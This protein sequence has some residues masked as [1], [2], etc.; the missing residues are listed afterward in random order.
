[1][2]NSYCRFCGAK[3]AEEDKFCRSCGAELNPAIDSEKT[4]TKKS[5]DYSA[6]IAIGAII[7]LVLTALIIVIRMVC[8]YSEPVSTPAPT[9]EVISPYF[10]ETSIQETIGSEDETKQN[11]ISPEEFAI[12]ND[13]DWPKSSP[14]DWSTSR[15]PY[16]D[17]IKVLSIAS[18]AA[19]SWDNILNYGD[20]DVYAYA[21]SYVEA[22]IDGK[23]DLE[24][25]AIGLEETGL[26]KKIFGKNEYSKYIYNS[27]LSAGVSEY[28]AESFMEHECYVWDA[29]WDIYKYARDTGKNHEKA[30]DSVNWGCFTSGNSIGFD[31]FYNRFF[32]YSNHV[33]DASE[34][35]KGE[36]E[37]LFRILREYYEG[38]AELI[39]AEKSG[40]ERYVRIIKSD[41]YTEQETPQSSCFS[42]VGYDSEKEELHV[43]FRTSGIEYIYYKFHEEDWN[44]FISAESLGTYFN[45]NI[46]GNFDYIKAG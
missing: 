41:R 22:R 20:D 23:C 17:R 35:V 37:E 2:N 12:E 6:F 43:V 45:N 46:K 29:A 8:N 40:G 4:V 10:P 1:M 3:I 30:I 44:S 9:E 19:S 33:S 31:G 25:H 42:K 18:Q 32:E 36:R 5:V 24:A 39:E 13:L 34:R 14:V 16:S 7:L 27:A 26:Y 11:L 38:H 21:T 28:D 15:S